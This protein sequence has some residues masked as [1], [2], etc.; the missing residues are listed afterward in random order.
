MENNWLEKPIEERISW[1]RTK[2]R[3]LRDYL[4][5]KRSLSIEEREMSKH[6][7][8]TIKDKASIDYKFDSSHRK[9][10]QLNE[11]MKQYYRIVSKAYVQLP[12]LNSNPRKW[13][14]GLYNAL[15]DIEYIYGRDIS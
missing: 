9:I 6:L 14:E 2:I 13:F 3:E 11:E 12:N 1:Y 7:L 5:D 4:E 8:R 10:S 15:D